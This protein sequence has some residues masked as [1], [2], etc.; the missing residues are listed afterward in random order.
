MRVLIFTLL[1]FSKLYGQSTNSFIFSQS[2]ANSVSVEFKTT[3]K[4]SEIIYGGGISFFYNKGN[5]GK[6]YTGFVPNFA[7]SSYER[8]LSNDGS[9]F[10]ILGNK[11][12][13]R[14]YCNFRFGLG[15]Q[16]LFYNGVGLP[17]MPSELWYVRQKGYTDIMFGLNF[18][19]NVGNFS[20]SAGWDK[21]NKYN[22]GFGFNF[23][24][25]K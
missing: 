2:S 11:I 24:D 19:Y 13:E 25:K 23:N 5:K 10:A 1:A 14:L 22:F 3:K 12:N 4:T 21:F 20:L 8:I 9:I 7:A 18:Q 17:S 6:D 15:V 16:T